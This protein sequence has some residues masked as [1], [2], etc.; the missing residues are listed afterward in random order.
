M[1][2]QRG[3]HRNTMKTKYKSLIYNKKRIGK[4]KKK[5]RLSNMEN[6][7]S[8]TPLRRFC[9]G[10]LLLG[11][12]PALRN[13]QHT[14]CGFTG[15]NKLILCQRLL[16]FRYGG[17]HRHPFSAQGIPLAQTFVGPV[18]AV[19]FSTISYV[20]QSC[21]VQKAFILWCSPSCLYLTIFPHPL[22]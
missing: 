9:V 18:N 3:L 7:P 15:K 6:I 8:K 16:W 13:G 4:G 1:Y 17:L 14:Q 5:P 20:Q 19:T 2:R 22:Q 12:E 11:W 21:C 10:L